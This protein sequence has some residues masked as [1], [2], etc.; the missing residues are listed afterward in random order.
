MEDS[1]KQTAVVDGMLARLMR[2]LT[3]G[4][5]EC[6]WFGRALAGAVFLYVACVAAFGTG[7]MNQEGND[8]LPLLDGAWRILNGQIPHR[9]FY[10]ALGPLEY[11][12]AAGGM[13][14]TG[15]T[16]KGLSVGIAI[17]GACIGIW[18]WRISR[19]RMPQVP[20]LLVTAWLALTATCPAPLDSTPNAVSCAMIYN[21][22]GYALLA[23]VLV[24]CAFAHE[25]SRFWGGVSS[26]VI[27]V[28]LLFLKL[29]FLGAAVLLLLVT[30]PLR[31][32]ELRRWWGILA[33]AAAVFTTFCLYLRFALKAFSADMWLAIHSRS[34][35]LSFRKIAGGLPGSG[36]AVTLFLLTVVT[37]LLV[38]PGGF[39]RSQGVRTIL[40]ACA[41]IGVSGLLRSTNARESGFYL[42]A[43]WNVVLVAQLAAAYPEAKKKVAIAVLA[44]VGLGGIAAQFYTGCLSMAALLKYRRPSMWSMGMS[45]TGYKMDG[46]RFFDDPD[47]G[48]RYGDN[49]RLYATYISDG[50]RLLESSSQ[51]NEKVATVGFHNPFS[52]VLRRKPATGGSTFLLLDNN[53]TM[54]HLPDPQRIFGDADLIME[55][56]YESTHEHSDLLIEEAYRPYLQEHYSVAGQSE[57]WT[58]YRRSQ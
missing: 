29:N 20:A 7:P 17:A 8:A 5:G 27:V 14:L 25:R 21:R 42:M 37:V 33:G 1:D 6:R 40:L 49:G 47:S 39:R 23:I 58:L 52:Y 15:C 34:E 32:G 28:L 4:E 16:P 12:I 53:I 41:T 55:P 18:G 24:E 51:P 13:W 26:G 46:L 50:V 56:H 36:E 2:W 38:A 31:G 35:S 45:V 43:L 30:V 11:M 22:L 3:A 9:D 48:T 44:A 10:S 54:A 19:P 57:W